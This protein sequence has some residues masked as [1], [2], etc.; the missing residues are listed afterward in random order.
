MSTTYKISLKF[1]N[2][3][4]TTKRSLTINDANSDVT[5]E[6]VMQ[7]GTA[8]NGYTSLYTDVTK[9]SAANLVTTETTDLLED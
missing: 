2:D 1:T 7:F 4:G 6:Q 8:L 9:V 3:D 5:K